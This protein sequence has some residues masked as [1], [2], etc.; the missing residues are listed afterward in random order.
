MKFM[1]SDNKQVKRIYTGENLIFINNPTKEEEILSRKGEL[2]RNLDRTSPLKSKYGVFKGTKGAGAGTYIF[3]LEAEEE[4]AKKIKTYESQGG[5]K[6]YPFARVFGNVYV[7]EHQKTSGEDAN[8]GYSNDGDSDTV[9]PFKLSIYREATSPSIATTANL[10]KIYKGNNLVWSGFVNILM[11][12]EREYNNVAKIYYYPWKIK[13][14]R[15][16]TY[17]MVLNQY[18]GSKYTVAGVLLADGREVRLKN[19]NGESLNANRI[20]SGQGY[21][22]G[23]LLEGSIGVT[24]G[25][26]EV[27][28][29]VLTT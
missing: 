4:D 1:T 26:S 13:P 28:I 22:S 16:K 9:N 21:V 6:E 23:D 19:T 25:T 10:R 11:R 24:F 15:G 3:V 14:Q 7:A 18:D 17:R 5:V 8:F 12:W 27:D 2:V 29:K 20:L